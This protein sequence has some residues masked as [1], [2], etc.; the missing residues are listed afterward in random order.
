[1]ATAASYHQRY[2]PGQGTDMDRC[3]TWPPNSEGLPMTATS[4]SQGAPV[5]SNTSNVPFAPILFQGEN[6]M[7]LPAQWVFAHMT[8]PRVEQFVTTAD[9]FRSPYQTTQPIPPLLMLPASAASMG[10]G[11]T[12]AGGD[13][14][15]LEINPLA[16]YESGAR[17]EA[18]GRGTNISLD[19]AMAMQDQ[20]PMYFILSRL[21]PPNVTHVAAV[22]SPPMP[23][24][25]PTEESLHDMLM[26]SD[27]YTMDN[28]PRD[29]SISMGSFDRAG[30]TISPAD[31]MNSPLHSSLTPT[32]ATLS[33]TTPNMIGSPYLP[34][35]EEPDEGEGRDY[36]DDD[37]EPD[38]E[39]DVDM[40][41]DEDNDN[42]NY[43]GNRNSSIDNT[44]TNDNDIDAKLKSKRNEC[45]VCHKTFTRRSNL[46]THERLHTRTH[47][48]ACLLCGCTFSRQPDLNRHLQAIHEGARIH[49]CEKCGRSF[50][51]KD[52]WRVHQASCKRTTPQAE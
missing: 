47:A 14:G 40:D 13:R 2:R 42:D 49:S 20:R 10:L 12:A 4:E 29:D 6:V 26:V 25:Q 9:L 18:Q 35:K 48:V 34:T 15:S 1:M 16:E 11:S 46:K 39:N 32:M 8:P 43:K 51:R 30:M 50:S 17:L 23:P 27:M 45:S 37:D 38:D 52:A 19:I 7:A 21:Q 28:L 3:N 36:D 22:P 24:P 44:A 33:A 5:H 41:E 31:T